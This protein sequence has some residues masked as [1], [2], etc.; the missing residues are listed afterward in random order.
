[1]LKV[2]NPSSGVNDPMTHLAKC[3]ACRER[4]P[5]RLFYMM[6]MKLAGPLSTFGA[7]HTAEM[8]LGSKHIQL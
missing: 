6:I 8:I 1:M 5:G 7:Y 4:F 2:Y 3:P